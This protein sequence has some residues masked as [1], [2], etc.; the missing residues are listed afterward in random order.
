MTFKE[1]D[2]YTI[3]NNPDKV[4]NM[5]CDNA[6]HFS[7]MLYI[8]IKGNNYNLPED[9]KQSLKSLAKTINDYIN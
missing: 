6:K 2:F 5:I 3:K 8:I 1:I 7:N 9:V 4:H